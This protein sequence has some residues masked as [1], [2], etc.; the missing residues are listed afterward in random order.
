MRSLGID[1]AAEPPDTAACEITWLADSAHGR[2]F[3]GRLD[4][5]PLLALIESADKAGIDCPFGWPEPFVNAVVAHANSAPWP[6]RGQVGLRHR[7]S[8][9]Y[10][11]TELSWDATL[12]ANSGCW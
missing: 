6:G 8:L 2:L 11:L 1:L 12:L 10:R 5:E 3:P 4:D 9:R 7:R